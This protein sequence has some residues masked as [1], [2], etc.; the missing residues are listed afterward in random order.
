[1]TR[2]K[3]RN[4]TPAFKAKIALEAHIDGHTVAEITEQHDAHPAQV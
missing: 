3:R 4:Q 2:R 1:M